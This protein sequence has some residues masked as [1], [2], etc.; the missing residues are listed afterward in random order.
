MNIM[1]S[2]KLYKLTILIHCPCKQILHQIANYTSSTI[3]VTKN[4]SNSFNRFGTWIELFHIYCVM[5]IVFPGHISHLCA[6]RQSPYFANFHLHD[7]FCERSVN[8]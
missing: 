3:I 8:I 5:I 1:Q 6:K 2:P 7:N 4:H